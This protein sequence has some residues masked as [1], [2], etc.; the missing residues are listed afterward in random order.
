MYAHTSWTQNGTLAVNGWN[1]SSRGHITIEVDD[2]AT[3][4][5]V[6]RYGTVATGNGRFL[7]YTDYIGCYQ[8]PDS[9]D[10]DNLAVYVRDDRSDTVIGPMVV[11]GCPS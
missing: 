2:A 7:I 10:Y 9:G 3:G 11:D 4:D 6:D 8:N 1:L 5:L